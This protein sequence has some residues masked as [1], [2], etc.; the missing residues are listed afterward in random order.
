MNTEPNL[1]IKTKHEFLNSTDNSQDPI[2]NA[3]CKYENHPSIILIKKHMQGANSSF[4]FETVTKEKIEKLITNLNIRKA[5]QSNDIPTKLV[6]EFGY[7]FSKYIATSINRCIT[8]GTF[9]NAF[10]KAEVRPI[11]KKDGRTEKSNY[12]P[13]SVLSNV[14]KIYERCLYEQMYSYFDKIFSKNQCGF[15]KGFNTQHILLA[16]IE[17]MKASRDNKQF[18]AAIL[19]DLSKAFDCICYDL[20]IAKLNAYGFDKKALKLIYD[21]LNGRSQKI[22]VV[23]S[24]SSELDISYGV[25]QGSTL[26][27]LLFNIDISDYCF[28][29][30]LLL[31]LQ[32]MLMTLLLTNVINTVII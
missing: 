20:L 9:V 24:F 21:Y 3:I 4:V 6:K 2:E 23:S 26:C 14:S 22:K 17:K 31:T 12:R 1:G 18:C 7:L 25:P 28:F 30:T 19:T 5:V 8:G 13:I 29:L 32:I 11:Y 27:P 16:M 10:K 15:R